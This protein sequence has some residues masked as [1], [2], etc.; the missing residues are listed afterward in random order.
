MSRFCNLNLTSYLKMRQIY[1]SFEWVQIPLQALMSVC[2][3]SFCAGPRNPTDYYT[4]QTTNSVALVRERTIPTER[5]PLVGEA[6]ISSNYVLSCTHEVEW[7]L[8]Q[9]HYFSEQ[10]GIA[11]NRTRDLG[12]CSQEL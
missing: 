8:F 2:F 9:T 4:K 7:T 1:C 6:T 10:F 3:Y 12:I 11:G 5:P